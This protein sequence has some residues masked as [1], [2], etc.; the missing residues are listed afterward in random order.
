MSAANRPR[1]ASVS[2]HV[3]AI[4]A[5]SSRRPAGGAGSVA[6]D[7]LP[8]AAPAGQ[9]V[10][11]GH[12]KSLTPSGNRYVLRFDP[13]WLL[14]GITGQRAAVDDGVLPPGEPV[15]NDNYT[16]D[17]SHKLLTFLVPRTA[18]ITVLTNSGTKGIANTPV[19]VAE[20]AQIL[21]GKNPRH[22][23]LFGQPVRLGLLGARPDRHR[24]LARRAV[25]PVEL[26]DAPATRARARG[27][28]LRGR[29]QHLPHGH[30][31]EVDEHR[32]ARRDRPGRGPAR[33]RLPDR[34]PARR[35]ARSRRPDRARPSPARDA[36]RAR[37]DV[38]QVRPAA[39]D[40]AGH[41]PAGHHRRA[42]RAPGR[43]APV[44][45]RRRRAGDP[46]GAR[47]ADRAAL[48]RVRRGADGRGVDRPGAPRGAA[49]RPP[50]RGQGAAAARAAAGRER[51]PAAL[52]GGAARARARARARLRRH[53]RDR[54]RVR[55]LDP[56]GA[57]LPPGGPQRRRLPR[58]LRRPS[59]RRGAARLLELHPRARADA[60]APRRRAALGPRAR[61]V[62]RSSS[63]AGSPT[64]SPT[65]G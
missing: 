59:A 43:R 52:P 58:Q 16:R 33:L 15:P 64:S 12:I 48:P 45:V 4:V 50:R 18:R 20:F 26:R 42:A 27:R 38:R 36:R 40:A 47:P 65:P 1:A 22:R 62:A 55:A 37:P 44:P 2:L 31:L 21:K 25:P 32:P 51:H 34:G 41:R 7:Q 49:E 57:R 19:T 11:Y 61:R 23:A 54:R 35:L 56:P 3:R 29:V 39:L 53:A 10:F 14:E 17:E 46:R 30:E 8:P 24:A 63:A 28:G 9:L 6:L 5:C 13:A 60:G